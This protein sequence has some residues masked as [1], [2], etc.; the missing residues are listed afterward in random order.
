MNSAQRQEQDEAAAELEAYFNKTRP[1][2]LAEGLTNGVGNVLS[3]AIGTV[4]SVVLM[5]VVGMAAGYEKGGVLGSAVGLVGGAVAGVVGGAMS[6]VGGI[7][8]GTSQIVRGVV[9]V[10]KSISGPMKG[11]WWNDIDGKW[12]ETNLEKEAIALSIV[13]EDD[14]DILGDKASEKVDTTPHEFHDPHVKD[15]FYYDV[16]GVSSDANAAKIKRQYYLLARKYHPDKVGNDRDAAEMFKNIS[17]AYQVLADP[18][19]R[20]IYDREGLDGLT[21]DKTSA[22][23]VENQPDPTILFAFL[24]GSDKFYDYIGRLAVA[25]S[26]LI[27]TDIPI[28]DARKLQIR[29][30]TRI[31]IKLAK[32]LDAWISPDYDN[33][34]VMFQ[35]KEEARALSEASYGH[36]LVILIGNVYSLSATQ[37]LGSLDSGIG[38]PSITKWVKAQSAKFRESQN[39]A[40]AQMTTLQATLSTMKKTKDAETAMS[41]AKTQAERNAIAEEMAKE[42]LAVMLQV[43]WTMTAVD[44]TSTLHEAIQMVLFDRSIDKAASKRRAKGIRKLGEIFMACPAVHGENDPAKLY[45][46]AAFAAMI[47]TVKR[48]EDSAFRASFKNEAESSI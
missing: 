12:V 23:Y 33:K 32:K 45:E 47:E 34:Y 13:P 26:A 1:R 20:A 29:R 24:F 35:W 41:A 25:T 9:S 6:A 3:G 28:K 19:L 39:G 17:E 21:A 31:A 44:I 7:L 11:M 30:C 27:G 42:H 8:K 40:K 48:K 15:P 2:N 38:M 22:A 16:L 18:D 14:N 5:P 36:E 4:G 10:P 46:E 43:M 37:F